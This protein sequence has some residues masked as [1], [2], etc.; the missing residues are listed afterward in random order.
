VT[1]CIHT[2][3]T[4][5]TA[6]SHI[7]GRTKTEGVWK[8]DDQEKLHNEE[9]HDLYPSSNNIRMINSRKMRGMRNVLHTGKKRNKH[10]GMKT[11]RKSIT[12]KTQAW[13]EKH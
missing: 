13:M 7:T 1:L 4:F 6:V 8:Q 10:F 11:C 2:S 9:L 5:V 3:L 12:W